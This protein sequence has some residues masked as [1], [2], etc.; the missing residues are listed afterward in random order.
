[1]A[2]NPRAPLHESFGAYVRSQ[3]ELA[4][5]TLRQAAQL[6]RISNPYLSQ[7]EH[8][9]TLPSVTVL[10]ALADALQ[11]SADTFLLRA[12]GVT[13]REAPEGAPATEDAIRHDP[14]LDEAQKKALLGVLATFTAGTAPPATPAPRRRQPPKAPIRKKEVPHA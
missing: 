12:A 6:A 14:R 13:P 9:V 3:R 8:G 4:Q 11:V 1:M 7:I 2:Q 10:S 5:L